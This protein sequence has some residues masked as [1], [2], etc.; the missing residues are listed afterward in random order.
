[1]FRCLIDALSVMETGSEALE[2][3]SP[4]VQD[5]IKGYW[6]PVVHFDLKPGNSL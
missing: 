6:Q 2:A 1:M 3:E 5:D 4:A